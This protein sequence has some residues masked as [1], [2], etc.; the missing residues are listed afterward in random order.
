MRNVVTSQ[1]VKRHVFLPVPHGHDVSI[2]T[3]VN[4][5]GTVISIGSSGGGG[6][7]CGSSGGSGTLSV[8][9]H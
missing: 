9:L 6:G 5:F 3:L 8:L 4:D 2:V 1:P 7:S